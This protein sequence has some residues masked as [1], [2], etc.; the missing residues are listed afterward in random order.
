MG[1]RCRSQPRRSWPRSRRS[2]GDRGLR[3]RVVRAGNGTITRA[4]SGGAARPL[5]QGSKLGG[6][7][8]DG[9]LDGLFQLALT[10]LAKAALAARR[11][12]VRLFLPTAPGA[13]GEGL[14]APLAGASSD[15]ACSNVPGRRIHPK[16]VRGGGGGARAQARAPTA[17]NHFVLHGA[18]LGC[19]GGVPRTSKYRTYKEGKG[20]RARA[21][22]PEAVTGTKEPS[23]CASMR[24]SSERPPRAP[25][26]RATS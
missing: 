19:V 16:R 4:I 17:Q 13:G 18:P 23:Q 5:D 24:R 20:P 14:P 1:P 12:A 22:A 9:H 10:P 21:N 15:R 6:E 26:H 8:L 3:A 11:L 25:L 7:P 2:R